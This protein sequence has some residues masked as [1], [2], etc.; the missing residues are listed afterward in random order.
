MSSLTLALDQHLATLRVYWR[1]N[2][3]FPTIAELA[4][5]LGM[6]STGGVHKTL[7]KHRRCWFPGACGEPLRTH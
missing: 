1:A 7:G 6:A 2:R 4:L 3:T 5:V